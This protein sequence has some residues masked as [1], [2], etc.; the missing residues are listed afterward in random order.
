[1]KEG[2]GM[3][4]AGK[5]LF[6]ATGWYFSPYCLSH[7]RTGWAEPQERLGTETQSCVWR[8]GPGALGCVHCHQWS[9]VIKIV[10]GDFITL[11]SVLQNTL[12]KQQI[13]RYLVN[14]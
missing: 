6:I 2:I 13:M 8:K 3:F 1:M 5:I 12:Q 7:L 4:S 11:S 9:N 14:L 10:D